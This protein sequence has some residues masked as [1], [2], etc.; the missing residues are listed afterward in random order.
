MIGTATGYFY[1]EYYSKLNCSGTKNYVEGYPT[2]V[3]MPRMNKTSGIQ[4]GSIIQTCTNVGKSF[5]IYK[6]PHTWHT[7]TYNSLSNDVY[8]SFAWKCMS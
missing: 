2:G 6:H 8:A 4:M 3:C 7:N 1:A 5:F